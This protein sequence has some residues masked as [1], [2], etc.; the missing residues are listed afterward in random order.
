MSTP[1]DRPIVIADYGSCEGKNSL[2][3]MRA[4]IAV[5]RARAG[6]RRPIFVYHTDL[7]AN[8]FSTMFEMLESDPDSYV[9]GERN[10]FP[11]AIGRLFYHALE[12]LSASPGRD[13]EEC[14]S[15]HRSAGLG[16]LAISLIV[17][18]LLEKL[19]HVLTYNTLLDSTR[20][21]IVD[22]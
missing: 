1:G 22:G 3:P 13:Q 10:V 5:L 19:G 17:L 9:R 15:S 7:P 2:A 16:L 18:A 6:Q 11:S 21:K 12:G 8:D 20:L 4:A 14:A